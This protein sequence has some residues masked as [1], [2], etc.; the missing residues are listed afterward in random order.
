MRPL[1]SDPVTS[2]TMRPDGGLT[3]NA[4]LSILERELLIASIALGR[5]LEGNGVSET[6]WSRLTLSLHRIQAMR[7]GA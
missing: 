3:F 4:K 5:F 2:R 6:D 1:P 7:G